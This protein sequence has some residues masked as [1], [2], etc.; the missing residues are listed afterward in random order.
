M[1]YDTRIL[2]AFDGRLSFVT[3]KD[4]DAQTVGKIIFYD[5]GDWTDC[6][7][8]VRLFC[9]NQMKAHGICQTE[10]EHKGLKYLMIDGVGIRP[11]PPT[12]HG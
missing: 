11:L 6:M 4:E 3:G 5:C 12:Y 2:D 7:R 10:G 1:R 8:L 9:A